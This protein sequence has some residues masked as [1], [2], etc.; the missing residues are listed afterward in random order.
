MATQPIDLEAQKRAA[1]ARGLAVQAA[2]QAATAAGQKQ[3]EAQGAVTQQAAATQA[4]PQQTKQLTPEQEMQKRAAQSAGQA[5]REASV[6][7]TMAGQQ[8]QEAQ[9]AAMQSASK[10]AAQ[11]AQQAGEKA[12]LAGQNPQQPTPPV[13]ETV[14]APGYVPPASSLPPEK[15]IAAGDSALEAIL[16]Q[17]QSGK[18]SPG[19]QSAIESN[20]EILAKASQAASRQ[21]AAAL[22]RSG[23]IGQGTQESVN[24]GLQQ[25]VLSGLAAN[26]NANA[27]LVAK[28]NQRVQELAIQAGESARGRTQQNEQFDKSQ[29]QQESQFGRNLSSQN[30]QFDKSLNNSNLQQD[31]SISSS[32]RQQDKSIASSERQQGKAIASSELQQDKA[33]ASSN[34]QFD[35]SLATN[36]RTSL[37]NMAERLGVDNPVLQA[38]LTDYILAGGTGEIGSFTPQEKTQIQDYLAKKQGTQDKY[39][40]VLQKILESVPGQIDASNQTLADEKVASEKTKSIDNAKTALGSLKN[41]A[42]LDNQQFSLLLESGDIPKATAKT[43]PKDAGKFLSENPSG[44]I[45]VDGEQYRITD[46]FGGTT[47]AVDSSG[48]DVSF[49]D[50]K[51]FYVKSVRG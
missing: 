15:G 6:T 5:A 21:A 2:S 46:S 7:A 37:L 16:G 50:G 34:A 49:H 3:Q 22:T 10:V 4:I 41:G 13:P 1:R 39:D 30:Q 28:D 17:L 19:V 43:V 9:G 44:I 18:P 51:K 45:S 38:K 48:R 40:G 23:S 42:F 32:E 11:L 31:K 8:Q 24:R 35:K 36:D 14:V 29:G 27:D 20:R 33:L 25:D 26:E 47:T 12:Q